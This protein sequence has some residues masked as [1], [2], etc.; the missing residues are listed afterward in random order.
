M[1][2]RL[3]L[4]SYRLSSRRATGGNSEKVWLKQWDLEGSCF[5]LL[6]G[7]VVEGWLSA[8]SACR[9]KALQATPL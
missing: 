7:I 9:P 4:Q 6:R 3:A 8:L 1:G 2:R 5:Q